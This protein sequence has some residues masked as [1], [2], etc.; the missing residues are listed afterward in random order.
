MN[1]YGKKELNQL[2]DKVDLNNKTYLLITKKLAASKGYDPDLLSISSRPGKKLNYNGT[3][4]GS[5]HNNDFIIYSVMA[6]NGD[7]TKEEAA[8]HRK[9]YLTRARKIKGEWKTNKESPNNLAIR[10][11]WNG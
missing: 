10:I 7:I 3:H 4:F 6:K 1:G 9:R 8:N 2:L 11:L 5:S